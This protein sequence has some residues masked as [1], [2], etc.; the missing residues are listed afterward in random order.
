M[1]CVLSVYRLTWYQVRNSLLIR[2]LIILFVISLALYAMNLWVDLSFLIVFA[3]IILTLVALALTT[4]IHESLHMRAARRFGVK[5]LNLKVL[6]LGNVYYTLNSGCPEK[7]LIAEEPYRRPHQY[8]CMVLW[9]IS[10]IVPIVVSSIIIKTALI[11]MAVLPS[12][13]LAS[14]VC[15][16]RAIHL[17]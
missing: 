6:G 15:T 8:L 11:L 7:A 17:L 9:L 16:S 12:V 13:L 10:Y 1:F 14:S 5:V 2:G 3:G 4:S